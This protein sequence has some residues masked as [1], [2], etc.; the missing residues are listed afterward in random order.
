M[1]QACFS[2]GAALS[3]GAETC[4]LCGTEVAITP[5]PAGGVPST[6]GVLPTDGEASFTAGVSRYCTNCG[7]RPPEGSAFCN[8][9]GTEMVAA[10]AGKVPAP[11]KPARVLAPAEMPEGADKRPSSAV[12]RRA[13]AVAGVGLLVVLGLYGITLLS[14]RQEPAPSP[15]QPPIAEAQ[16]IPDEVPPLPDSLQAIADEF[17]S[18]ETAEGWYESGRYYLTA[19]FETT[20]T[21]PTA[22]VQWARRAVADFERSLEIEDDPQVRVALAEASTFDPTNPM[23][24][25]EELQTVLTADPT[26]VDA[27]FLLGERRLM[28]GRVDSARAAFERVLAAAPADSPIRQRAEEALAS[29]PTSG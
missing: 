26:N 25:V 23:R 11:P 1:S 29:L 4:D 20:Q 2:C 5:E 10:P 3:E 27:N 19:S 15:Q 22:S 13:L 8:V 17:A 28:I 14:D 16:P 18:R 24:A 9:C 6:P 7:H 12:G 21:N